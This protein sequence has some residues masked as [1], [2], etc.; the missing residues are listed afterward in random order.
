M[1]Q[2]VTLECQGQCWML[3]NDKLNSCAITWF[4]RTEDGRAE[5]LSDG[6]HSLPYSVW[7]D[8]QTRRFRVTVRSKLIINKFSPA[9]SGLYFCSL[10]SPRRNFTSNNVSL[11]PCPAEASSNLSKSDCLFVLLVCYYYYHVY[12]VI[13]I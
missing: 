3:Y 12:V 10:E 1:N 7:T 6:C 9:Y 4:R 8:R 11:K 13:L 5:A 2:P